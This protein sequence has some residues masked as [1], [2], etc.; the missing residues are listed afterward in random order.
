M[1]RLAI[2]AVVQFF[3]RG[4]VKMATTKTATSQISNNRFFADYVGTCAKSVLP[5]VT[6]VNCTQTAYSIDQ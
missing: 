6:L 5:S 4:M 1:P 3:S 2:S